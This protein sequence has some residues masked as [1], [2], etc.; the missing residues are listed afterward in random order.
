MTKIPTDQST[1]NSCSLL[2][3]L[4]CQPFAEV[5]ENEREI[6]KVETNEQIFRC[7]RCNSYINSKYEMTYSKTNK[8]IAVCNI[9]ACEN[10]LDSSKPSVKNEYFSSNFS[11]VPELSCPTVDF[12][13]PTSMKHAVP[14]YPHYIFMIDIS[15]SSYEMGLSA[16]VLNSITSNLDY[17]HNAAGSHIAIATYDNKSIQFF[18]MDKNNEVK[19]YIVPDIDNPFCPLPKSKLFLNVVDSRSDIEKV[20]E[21]INFYI[22]EKYS[23]TSTPSKPHSSTSVTGAAIAA[24][25]NALEENGGRVMVFTCNSCTTGFGGCRPKEEAKLFNTKD[26][27]NLYM[28]QHQQ[29]NKLAETC[30]EKRIAVDQFV[31][32][33]TQFD[34]ATFGV[35]SDLTGGAINFY[36]ASSKD[37]TELKYKLEKMH[38]DFSR[39]LTR[40]NY[41]DVK[42]MLRF[43]IG[44]DTQEIL[45]P[46]NK[47]LGE[48]FQL[49]SCDPDYSY[50]YNLRLS[51]SLKNNGRYHFQLV[52][53]YIDNF[54]QRYLR[55][56][57]YTII[58]TTDISKIYT[59][60]DVDCLAKL[61]L[62]KEISLVHQAETNLVRENLMNKLINSFLYYRVQ[63][64]KHT[65]VAQLILPASIKYL[66][67]YYNSFV[68]KPILKKN[69]INI[70]ANHIISLMN[71]MMREPVYLTV[72]Y[73]Y[74]KFYRIDD[75][76]QDQ[77]VKFKEADS[78]F[79]LR[80]VG[81]TNEK[82]GNITKP[83]MLPL[84]LDHV[85]F[86]CAYLADDGE[87]ISLFIFNYIN[88][89]FYQELFGVD[90]FEEAANLGVESLD[91][92]N[93]NDLN[94]RILN[95]VAQ[96]RKE[97]KGPTQ[98]VK[99]YF[100]E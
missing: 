51:E 99:I 60:A 40:P 5:Q 81:L 11:N 65:P 63:C 9:C 72:K 71:K 68:K 4:Y 90:T 13:A 66:P 92:N 18:A 23:Q 56:F 62:M 42:F 55:T 26:E 49:A 57:N 52:C 58:A 67:L 80:D 77:S 84:S 74:P 89:Q 95:I 46:F 48:A 29:F 70:P 24:G 91:E 34:L 94:V 98:P 39:I 36:S 35:I 6:P 31:V 10:E 45:G 97:N 22:N 85:D 12:I 64:S 8:P 33:N 19:A 2:F 86:Y 43:S 27:K 61:T 3:G 17:I 82:Y 50:C 88:P 96:L 59:S 100:I 14:F 41:Y 73:L 16:Y 76:Q 75:I 21:K 37:I 44:I 38:Y 69:K 15:Q 30:L 32:A 1:L 25:V 47:K 53:L 83:Y 54:N 93:T 20:I 78:E 79:I 28:P 7:R 87:F